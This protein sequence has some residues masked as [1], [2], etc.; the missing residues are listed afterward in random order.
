MNSTI[1]DEWFEVKVYSFLAFIM[2]IGA[3]LMFLGL[4]EVC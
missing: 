4:G 1:E 3:T 2:G